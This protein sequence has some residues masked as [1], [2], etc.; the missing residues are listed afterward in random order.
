MTLRDEAEASADVTMSLAALSEQVV[1]SAGFVPLTR[2]ASG[3][4]LTV[5]DQA[6]LR[7]RQLESSQDALRSVPGFTVSRSGGR[8]AVTSI[9]PRGGESDFTLI[10]VDGIR[11]ND[12]GGSYD[13]AH[14]PLFDLDRVEV[15]RGP[16]SAVYG[17]DAVGG[18]VQLVTRRGGPLR[19]TGLFEGGTFGTWRANGAANGTSGRLR[20]GGGVEQLTTD[21]YTGIAPGTGE[22]VSNDDYSRTDGMGSLGYLTDRWQLTGLIRGRPQR[23]RRARAV[24][25]RPE[26]HL[27]RRRHGLAQRQRDTGGRRVGGLAP[28]A[29]LPGAR[30][31]HVRRT[32]TARS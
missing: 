10:M 11:L 19:A 14:L 20:W 3:A 23:A 24:R 32:A 9:F 2:S 29:G 17:S 4:S 16:Q 30:V 18:V 21:G 25:Q 15:V 28:C 1:V 27:R 13:A 8:G 26:R 6:E 22:T 5:L 7:T 12:M 31:V